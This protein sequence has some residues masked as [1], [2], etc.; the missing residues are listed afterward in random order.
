MENERENNV[1]MRRLCKTFPNDFTALHDITLDCR[2]GEIL[3]LLGPNGAGKSTTFNILTLKECK[4]TGV[5]KM[6][7][8]DLHNADKNDVESLEFNRMGICPQANMLFE[9]MT[10]EEHF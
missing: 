4:S 5:V 10:V 8:K 6:L 7:G 2:K 3:G 9:V 1:E